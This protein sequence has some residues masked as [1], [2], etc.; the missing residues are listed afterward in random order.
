MDEKDIDNKLAKLSS[1]DEAK[2]KARKKLA[3]QNKYVQRITI[4]KHGREMFLAKEYIGATRKYT[5][6]LTILSEMNEKDDIYEL[7]PSMFDSKK[8]LTEML[9]ISHVYWELSRIYEMTPKLQKSYELALK[10][11]IKF[12]VNQPY[13][14]L[15]SE[16]L[17][18]YIKNNKHRSKQILALEKAFSQIQVESKKCYIA[19]HAFGQSH[20]VTNEL[21][22]FKE[23]KLA[24]AYGTKLTA[25][26]YFLSSKLV[27][28]IASQPLLGRV[29]SLVSRPPLYV[30]AFICK[31][32]MKK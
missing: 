10:Q 21:R 18:K 32:G 14:V 17:R 11:F 26:Y 1:K 16:M 9:L 24:G 3:L 19:T 13:Q 7:S 15:N 31:K 23:H 20:W 8:D 30:V 28:S 25:L 29:I 2:E 4:A 5:E 22:R 6:Y 27:E 12:T